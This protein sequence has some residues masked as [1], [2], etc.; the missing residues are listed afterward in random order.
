MRGKEIELNLELN[1]KRNEISALRSD[2]IK[3]AE[4]ECFA[5]NKLAEEKERYASEQFFA[6]GNH[7]ILRY[8][9]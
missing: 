8:F 3:A 5:Q 6:F 4:A 9:D 1:K 7:T 2:L